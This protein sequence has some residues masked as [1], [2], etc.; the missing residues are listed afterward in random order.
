MGAGAEAEAGVR[1]KGLGLK[2]LRT[3]EIQV[4]RH[5]LDDLE[6]WEGVYGAQYFESKLSSVGRGKELLKSRLR[7][8]WRGEAR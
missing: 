2:R 4:E 6:G 5:A 3:L 8:Q 7:E 1:L